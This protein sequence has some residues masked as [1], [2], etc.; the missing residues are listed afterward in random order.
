MTL[1]NAN[2]ECA[3]R[4]RIRSILVTPLVLVWVGGFPRE[5]LRLMRCLTLG[6]IGVMDHVFCV[7]AEIRMA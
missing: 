4:E 7:G 6:S 1:A 3:G 5:D 2:R